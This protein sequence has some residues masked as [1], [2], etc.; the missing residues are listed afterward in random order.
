MKSQITK[1]WLIYFDC[2]K[3]GVRWPVGWDFP[4]RSEWIMIPATAGLLACLVCS[5]IARCASGR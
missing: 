1:A 2:I 3:T 4:T 5:V